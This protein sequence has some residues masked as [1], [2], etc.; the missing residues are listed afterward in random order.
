MPQTHR[1]AAPTGRRLSPFILLLASLIGLGL[2]CQL[3]GAQPS[4]HVHHH[5]HKTHKKSL[6]VNV[7]A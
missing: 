7:N 5:R 4:C 1:G 6:N 3:A 2:A